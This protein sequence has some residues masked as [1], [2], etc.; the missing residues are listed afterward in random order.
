MPRNPGPH[1]EYY[2]RKIRPGPGALVCQRCCIVATMTLLRDQFRCGIEGCDH[3]AFAEVPEGRWAW[4]NFQRRAD[5]NGRRRANLSHDS[6]QTH[7]DTRPAATDAPGAEPVVWDF[8][9]FS[10]PE[11]VT[12]PLA[13]LSGS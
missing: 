8:S 7:T 10:Q 12:P 13:F 6:A 5:R 2:N 3:D 9:D 4:Q 1:D 11:A